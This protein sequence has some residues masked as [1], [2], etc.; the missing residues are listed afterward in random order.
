MPERGVI[1]CFWQS[2]A[3]EAAGRSVKVQA[4]SQPALLRTDPPV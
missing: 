3:W 1:P 2:S 4:D